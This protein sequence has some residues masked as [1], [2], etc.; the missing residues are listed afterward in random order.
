MKNR[1]SLGVIGGGFMASALIQ[2]ALDCGFL[3][4]DKIAVGEVDAAKREVFREKGVFSSPDNRLIAANCDYLLFAVKPQSFAAVAD[5]LDGMRLPVVFTIMA[6]KTKSAVRSALGG[7]VLVA[8]AMPN[9]PCSVGEGITGVDVSELAECDR[10]FCLGFFAASGKAVETEEGLMNAVTALSGS[11]PAYV[12][13]FLQ[14]LVRA[15]IEQGLT[16]ETAR[17]LAL[18][19]V[20]GGVCMAERHPEKDL[21]ELIDAV[22]SKG[23]TTVAALESFAGDDFTGSVARAVEAAKKRAEE[24]SK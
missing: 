8:R 7:R 4:A 18:Q 10:A 1:F 12:Y 9:L 23:G 15:G 13:L 24:L 11:G 22:S 6:G 17:E 20:K 5:E 21:Q 2:G 16:A 19:T 3:S 14:A